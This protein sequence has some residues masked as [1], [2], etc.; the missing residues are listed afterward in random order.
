[1]GVA[2]SYEITT[3][4]SQELR[5][6]TRNCS[7]DISVDVRDD[8]RFAVVRKWQCDVMNLAFSLTDK[9]L[10][11]R[12]T[13]IHI[14]FAI[15]EPRIIR[16]IDI[17]IFIRRRDM[18][19]LNLRATLRLPGRRSIRAH[20]VNVAGNHTRIHVLDI[21]PHPVYWEDIESM[22]SGQYTITLDLHDNGERMSDRKRRLLR[23]QKC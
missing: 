17:P 20:G 18:E 9:R 8:G 1:M 15:P 10:G 11:N 13:E 12:V 16:I 19:I 6:T 14:G 7:L 3:P 22:P 23:S 5:I 21:S 4:G 2:L